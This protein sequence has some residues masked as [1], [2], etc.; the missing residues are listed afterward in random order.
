M[1]IQSRFFRMAAFLSLFL[2]VSSAAL[3]ANQPL[4]IGVNYV[5]N[6]ERLY[7]DGCDIH[8]LSASAHCYVGHP[9]RVLSNG[10]MQ[11]TNETRGALT[12]LIQT[13]TPPPAAELARAKVAQQAADARTQAIE[14]KPAAP[15]TKLA[16]IA[17]YF[18]Q[19]YQA[20]RDYSAALGLGLIVAIGA[21]CYFVF[22]RRRHAGAASSVEYHDAAGNLKNFQSGSAAPP[23]SHA[24]PPRLPDPVQRAVGSG[25]QLS[26]KE[27]FYAMQ[28][29]KYQTTYNDAVDESNAAAA[30]LAQIGPI[31]QGVQDNLK[32]LSKALQDSVTALIQAQFASTGKIAVNA[33]MLKPV[34]RL[35]KRSTGLVKLIVAGVVIYWGYLELTRLVAGQYALF[36][37]VYLLYFMVSFFFEW[38]FQLKGPSL[39]VSKNAEEFKEIS[40][41][42][43]YEG[44]GPFVVNGTPTF[45]AL[46]ISASKKPP[47]EEITM[48]DN[49]AVTK[50]PGTF[51]L[52]IGSLAAYWPDRDGNA[53]L[54]FVHPTNEFMKSYAAL[55]NQAVGQQ[56]TFFAN[57]LPPMAQYGKA[58][59]R[60]RAAQ[61]KIP[62][63][64]KLV[65]DVDRLDSVWRNIYTS[66]KVFNFLLPRIDL[67]NMMAPAT[68]SGLLLYGYPGNGKGHLA[69]KIADSVSGRFEE[70]TA[71]KLATPDDVKKLWAASRGKQPVVLYVDYAERIFPKP[72]SEN[73]GGSSRE[74][75]L[76]WISQWQQLEAY[77]SRTWVVLS[78]QNDQDLHPAILSQIGGSKIE[79]TSPDAT[80]REIICAALAGPI[81]FRILCPT[82]S[83]RRR[84]AQAFETFKTSSRKR[85]CNPCRTHRKIRT[86]TQP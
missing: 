48:P 1:K 3:A 61:E 26:S 63:F 82:G 68:P 11:Y 38:R 34:V 23:V 25:Q 50:G 40:L 22:Y 31:A 51:L 13:C 67:F 12:Q 36:L 66:D 83:S 86:G 65:K 16:S 15:T 39:L 35:Y 54:A 46:R 76:E 78:A 33:A 14:G 2:G 37:S 8:D 80:G 57:T 75:T 70:V 29:D 62:E 21:T 5:C 24:I 55:V 27:R 43:C 20:P 17:Q 59:W 30:D 64:E 52:A 44:Q 71:S 77:Q 53:K 73:Q 4:V 19:Q 7:V 79:V 9:D 49:P 6:G 81:R 84:V 47:A 74:V 10:L 56:K 28:K 58:I 45:H 32:L 18:P 72:G 69:R 42:Y 41:V 60:R 85:N